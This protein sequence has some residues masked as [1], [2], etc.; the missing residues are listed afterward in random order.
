MAKAKVDRNGFPLSWKGYTPYKN[1][2][3]GYVGW[4]G[5]LELCYVALAPLSAEEAKIAGKKTFLFHLSKHDNPLD[6]AYS[7]MTFERDRKANI[8]VL[9]NVDTGCW[10]HGAIPTFAYPAEDTE[11]MAIRRENKKNGK[12]KVKATTKAKVKVPVIT[13]TEAMKAANVAYRDSGAKI[14]AEGLRVIR[15]AIEGHV[16]YYTNASDAYAHTRDLIGS[17]AA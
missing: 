5:S 7:A 11:A 9:A 1:V 13:V 3:Y 6:A 14:G 10:D 15:S 16:T 8:R 2:Y 4:A 12:A 17:M